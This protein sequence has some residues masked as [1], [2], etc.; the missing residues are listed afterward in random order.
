MILISTVDHTILV[1]RIEKSQGVGGNALEWIRSYLTGRSQRVS[2]HGATSDTVSLE[3]GLPQGSLFGPE[4]YNKYT[5]PLGKLILLLLIMYHFYADDSQLWKA[6]NPKSKSDTTSALHTLELAIKSISNW[7]RANKLKLNESKTEFLV[8]GSKAN[9]SKVENKHISVGGE[10]IQNSPAARNLGVLIDEQLSLHNHI[11]QV[12]KICRFHIHSIW[13]IRDYLSE[14]TT[15]SIVHSV[16][17]SRLDYC[18]ALYIN[19][20]VKLRDVLQKIMNEAARLITRTSRYDHITKTLIYLHWLPIKER[21]QFKVLVTTF[22]ALHN[23][24][25]TYISELLNQHV[26][27]RSLRSSSKC[28]LHEP[29]FNL[30]TAGYRSF[31]VAA[32]RIW[33]QLPDRIRSMDNLTTFKRELKTH[34][35]KSAYAGHL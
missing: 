8:I 30:Q 24:A 28:L 6:A 19:I 35:F 4:M 7:M 9:L 1:N 27:S 13:K 22:K 31:G 16:I 15:K 32:P 29:P 3:C 2:A 12:A 11:H 34:L 10:A 26:P 33:N 20:P 25:P 5:E 18:N 21:I 14:A 23:L 17:I